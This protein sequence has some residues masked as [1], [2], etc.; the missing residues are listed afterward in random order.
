MATVIGS[1]A[2]GLLIAPPPLTDP[3]FDRTVVLMAIHNEDGALGFVV[4]RAAPMTLGALLVHAG[5]GE[6]RAQLSGPVYVGGPVQP[7]SGWVLRIDP[8][9]AAG[10]GVIRVDD[11]IRVSSSRGDLDALVRELES[12]APGAPDP[13]R[14]MVL[15]GYSGWA[16]GQ[17]DGE[18]AAGAWLPVPLDE[19]IVFDPDVEH[20]WER[21]YRKLGLSPAGWMGTRGGGTA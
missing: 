4:N 9:S 5:Y 2:P 19:D 21:A 8:D 13:K 10:D 16:P 6:A 17:L 12:R 7:G 14:R 1:A 11:R 18:I 15:L 3:N 20:K